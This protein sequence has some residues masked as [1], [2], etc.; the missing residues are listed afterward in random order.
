MDIHRM[1]Q[2]MAQVRD[3]MPRLWKALYQGAIDQGF[4]REVALLLLQTW[5]LAQ[6]PHGI[7]P[8][9]VAGE[10]TKE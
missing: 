8:G 4:T 1:E 7:N 6:N 5:I 10:H 3:T 9:D 2:D